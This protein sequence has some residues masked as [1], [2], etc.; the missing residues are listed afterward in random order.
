[1]SAQLLALAGKVATMAKAPSSVRRS[2][3]NPS[4]ESERSVQDKSIW[5]AALAVAVR[6]VGAV[7]GWAGGA[8]VSTAS[9]DTQRDL[10]T[11]LTDRIRYACNAPGTASLSVHASVSGSTTAASFQTPWTPR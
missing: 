11:A 2:T 3:V 4:S 10:P 7:G 1:M 5:F 6:W 8:G 9:Q